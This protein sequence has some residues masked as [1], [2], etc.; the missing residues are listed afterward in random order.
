M[1]IHYSVI[2]HP[3]GEPGIISLCSACHSLVHRNIWIII[4]AVFNDAITR[5]IWGHENINK[6]LEKYEQGSKP[7][8]S[9]YK[10]IIERKDIALAK[11]YYFHKILYSWRNLQLL[12]C[13]DYIHIYYYSFQS[14]N[15]PISHH[16]L[17]V[18]SIWASLFIDNVNIRSR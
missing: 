3:S 17:L 16:D 5:G 12:S 13:L 8:L 7:Y 4:E 2:Q 18:L 14:K 15:N 6:T 10:L 11:L 1:I 9:A